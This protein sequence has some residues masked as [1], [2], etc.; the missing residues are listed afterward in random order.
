MRTHSV[1][2][3]GGAGYIGSH[4][5]KALAAAGYNPVVLD[6]LVTGHRW[7]AKWGAFIKGDLNNRELLVSV[8][9]ECQI[10]AVIHFAAFAYIGESMTDPGKYFRNNVVNTVNLLDAMVT[11][12]VD[13]LVFSSSCATYGIPLQLPINETHPQRPINPYGESKLFMEKAIHWYGVGHG[14]RSYALR[15]FNAAGDD[16]DGEIGEDHDPETH[17]IPLVIQ[18]ALG[19]RD[20]L[21]IFGADYDTPDGSAV[22]DY[23]HVKDLAEGHVLAVKNLLDGSPSRTLNLGT[24]V[25]LS[26]KEIIAAVE[27]A[28]SS[29]V[30]VVESPRRPG[31]P[32]ILVAAPRAAEEALGWKPRYSDLETIVGSALAWHA[33]Q[34]QPLNKR[35]SQRG[36]ECLKKVLS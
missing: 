1:L 15:Y 27:H 11:T 12:G 7:A 9:R 17:L 25:G 16:L 5:C 3:T 28:S 2:V 26:V 21:Q 35:T 8:L 34:M 30:N 31:D 4:T 32:A 23:I 33:K 13:N 36:S 29:P 14:I 19:Q 10:S 20:T 22:R 6:N 18:T 24:G